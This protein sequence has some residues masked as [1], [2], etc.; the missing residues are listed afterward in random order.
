MPCS[1]DQAHRV[2][3]V[4]RCTF[5]NSISCDRSA[6]ARLQFRHSRA[7]IRATVR[8]H[9]A[10]AACRVGHAVWVMPCGS[11]RV[12]H[13]VWGMPCGLSPTPRHRQ[14]RMVQ[15][16][17]TRRPHG[18]RSL[19]LPRQG[20]TRAPTS[21]GP[22]LCALKFCARARTHMLTC[23]CIHARAYTQ[24]RTYTHTRARAHTRTH[25]RTHTRAR[26]RT[27]TYCTHTHARTQKHAHM[28]TYKDA[29]KHLHARTHARYTPHAR[30]QRLPQTLHDEHGTR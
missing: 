9:R 15:L 8:R 1:T 24:A 13:A 30:I 5:Y 23:T 7:V 20:W 22:I 17:P 4:A 21:H 27:H 26:A 25:T 3:Q 2:L 28:H 6:Q 14:C 16:V 29:R 12:G 10:V 18:L 11:C 19:R